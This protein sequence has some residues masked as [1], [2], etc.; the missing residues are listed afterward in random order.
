MYGKTLDI[1]TKDKH[2]YY[3]YVPES[4]KLAQQIPFDCEY[5]GGYGASG[6]TVIEAGFSFMN[7]EKK[8]ITRNR[9]FLISGYYKDNEE[10]ISSSECIEKIYNKLVRVVKK[11]APYTELTDTCISTRDIDYLQEKELKHKEYIS[12]YLLE[13]NISQKYKLS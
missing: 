13:L 1:V 2:D 10:Y 3:F 12:P 9:L 7:D 4:G 11:V 6:I 5:I 8:E